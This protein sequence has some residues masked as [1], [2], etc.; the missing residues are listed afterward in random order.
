[1]KV[2]ASFLIPGLTTDS[3]QSTVLWLNLFFVEIHSSSLSLISA[4]KFGSSTI[5]GC[6]LKDGYGLGTKVLCETSLVLILV[7]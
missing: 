3:H 4:W 5:L 7:M 6:I 2:F 1:M